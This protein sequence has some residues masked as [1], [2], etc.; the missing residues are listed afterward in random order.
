[1]RTVRIYRAEFGRCPYLPDRTWVTDSFSIRSIDP[2]LYE[3]MLAEGW[4]RSGRTFYRNQ[5]P[6]C[7]ACI[8]IRV[9]VH[10][11]VPSRSQRRILRRNSDL[12]CE[13]LPAGFRDESYRLYRRYV[14]DRHDR[15]ESV[16]PESYREFLVDSPVPSAEMQYRLDGVLL[17][18]GWLD[19]LPGG[20]SSVYFAFDPEHSRRSLGTYSIMRE[21]EETR[22]LGGHW[23]YL[24]FYVP[25]S[26]SMDYKAR[27][28]PLELQLEQGTWT[29]I[30]DAEHLRSVVDSWNPFTRPVEAPQ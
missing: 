23:Y 15:G 1:M 11:F 10:S 24:G 22:R 4:R 21:I 13:L 27:F 29:A 14:R 18:V 16:Q 2:G 12:A 17:G 5:C 6:R 7:R 28:F 26:P 9:P 25:G 3:R 19:L 8:P 30:S 20:L